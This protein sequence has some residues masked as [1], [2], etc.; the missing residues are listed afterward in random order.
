M[1]GEK[2]NLMQHIFTATFFFTS[3]SQIQQNK[4]IV[5]KEKNYEVKRFYYL[6]VKVV[7]MVNQKRLL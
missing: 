1:K 2:R 6:F 4:E 5:A 7:L 3:F